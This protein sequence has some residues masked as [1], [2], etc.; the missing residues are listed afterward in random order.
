M[1]HIAEA[2]PGGR[3]SSEADVAEAAVWPEL[4]ADADISAKRSCC[5][6][7]VPGI[8]EM[9]SR[10]CSSSPGSSG[11][12]GERQQQNH[13]CTCW[14]LSGGTS[15]H[16]TARHRWQRPILTHPVGPSVWFQRCITLNTPQILIP[17]RYCHLCL[18][19]RDPLHLQYPVQLPAAR[20]GH[21]PQLWYQT[22][23]TT[24]Q[25]QLVF[26]DQQGSGNHL[27]NLIWECALTHSIWDSASKDNHKLIELLSAAWDP[28]RGIVSGILGHNIRS[29]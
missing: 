8:W 22:H 13:P 27:Q 3:C 6:S 20:G 11:V 19:R 21:Q 16:P 4:Q 26:D 14:P 2:R 1:S 25:R 29:R 17:L 18:S 15:M 7:S 23:S 28:P 10:Y 24:Q 12:H 5:C 9:G